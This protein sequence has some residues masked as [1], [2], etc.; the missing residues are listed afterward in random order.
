M[1]SAASVIADVELTDDIQA[2]IL[3]DIEALK[4]EGLSDGE[5]QVKIRE[6]YSEAPN[7]TSSSTTT[8]EES[9]DKSQ[10]TSESSKEGILDVITELPASKTVE[11]TSSKVPPSIGLKK[12][13]S[14][15]LPRQTQVVSAKSDTSR[16]RRRSFG[17]GL[18]NSSLLR[19]IF[20]K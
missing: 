5:I 8:E 3:K 12:P 16:T 15:K 4:T 9:K 7:A 18:T 13:L 20:C 10:E 1:G 19:L 17:Q 6:K 14:K 11:K 2:N